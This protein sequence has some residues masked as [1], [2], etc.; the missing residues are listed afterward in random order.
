[1]MTSC[2]F[3]DIQIPTLQMT[4]HLVLSLF[5]SKNKGSK[6]S[7]NNGLVTESPQRYF[8]RN[9]TGRNLEGLEGKRQE[10]AKDNIA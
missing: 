5:I 6:V 9:N 10:E 3:T 1:M 4:I 8:L 7:G 2:V